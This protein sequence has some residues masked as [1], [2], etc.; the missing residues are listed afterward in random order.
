MARH[1]GDPGERAVAQ[2][3]GVRARR[4]AVLP[5]MDANGSGE[6]TSTARMPAPKGGCDRT[7]GAD[8]V[9]FD[10]DGTIV[11]TQVFSG[12]VLRIDPR[13]G[14]KTVLAQLEPGLDNCT[15]VEGR[16]FVS[17]FTGAITEI[18]GDGG[19]RSA[20]P[21]RPQL[22]A[23]PRGRRRRR[24]LSPTARSSTACGPTANRLSGRCS[25]RLS[26]F[27][28]RPGGCRARRVRGH[29]RQ[30]RGGLVPDPDQRARRARR[31]LDQLYGVDLA[32]DGTP[33]WS[34][35]ARAE[36]WPSGPVAPGPRRRTRPAGRRDGDP[37]RVRA[38]VGQGRVVT[39]NNSRSETLVGGWSS[40]RVCWSAMGDSSSTPGSRPSSRSTDHRCP[41]DHRRQ[42][43]GR[44]PRGRAPAAR[45]AAVLR[46]ARARSP[47]SPLRLMAPYLSA[48][49]DG[50]VLALVFP[51][52]AR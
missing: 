18:L 52:V 49:A 1:P 12:Q 25:P 50:S 14:A 5:V 40:H 42:P 46:P 19:T 44:A 31:E 23:G 32:A 38:G 28:P 41:P 47:G 11:S 39:L 33:S 8:S 21:G 9:K 35:R 51:A 34:N 27:H 10:T 29:H 26:G 20:L 24:V 37:R 3:H 48:D 17:S 45:D 22:A 43:A 6:S 16:L 2:R 36:C 13:T 4:P 7:R 15:F 30:R